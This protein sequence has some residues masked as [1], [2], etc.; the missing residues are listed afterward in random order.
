MFFVVPLLRSVDGHVVFNVTVRPKLS[1]MYESTRG[2]LKY[3]NP[4]EESEGES[5][6]EGGV[7]MGYSTSLG[8]VRIVT[9]QE[10]QRSVSYFITE[11]GIYAV[12]ALLPMLLPFAAYSQAR[13]RLEAQGGQQAAGRGKKNT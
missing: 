4:L 9:E 5:E 3:V 12:L 13:G 8:R 6:G 11:W 10:Y 7:R 2:R 1:G